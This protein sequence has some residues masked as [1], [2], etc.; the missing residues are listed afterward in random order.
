MNFYCV[1]FYFT[2]VFAARLQNENDKK[3]FDLFRKHF[4]DISSEIRETEKKQ[5]K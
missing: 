2:D 3:R 5:Q 1:F 4:I